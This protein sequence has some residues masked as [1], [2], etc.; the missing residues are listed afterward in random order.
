MELGDVEWLEVDGSLCSSYSGADPVV[1]FDALVS[2]G[3]MLFYPPFGPDVL[4]VLMLEPELE[5]ELELSAAG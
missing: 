4:Q 1:L 2:W 3:L 5:L